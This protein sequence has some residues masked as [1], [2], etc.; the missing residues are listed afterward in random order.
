[1]CKVYT[2]VG[3]IKWLYHVCPPVS[4]IFLSLKVVDYLHVQADD[5]WYNYYVLGVLAIFAARAKS[6]AMA[7]FALCYQ[8][9][10][11]REET[12][13]SRSLARA[14]FGLTSTM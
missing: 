14:L 5:P 3:G 13:Y 9:T 2:D 8:L 1:M 10:E 6:R 7:N 11:G 12:V 4:K